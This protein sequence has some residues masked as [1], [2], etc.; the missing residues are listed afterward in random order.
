MR[1]GGALGGDAGAQTPLDRKR[2]VDAGDL[3][4]ARPDASLQFRGCR[5]PQREA[6]HE[7]SEDEAGCLA[8][9]SH[10]P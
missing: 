4:L 2:V 1:Q 7:E 10:A 8:V 9:Q 3:Q 6:E 5:W